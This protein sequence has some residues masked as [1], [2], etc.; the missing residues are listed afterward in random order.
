MNLAMSNRL[1]NTDAVA[2]DVLTL[3]DYN[4]RNAIS[5][6]T[7]NGIAWETMV[8]THV[9]GAWIAFPADLAAGTA[10]LLLCAIW[11]TARDLAR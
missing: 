9:E 3:R 7:I 2:H 10:V 4:N 6:G 5:P 11:K 1:R 8:C